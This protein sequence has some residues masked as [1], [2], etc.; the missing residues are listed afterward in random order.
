HHRRRPR[1]REDRRPRRDRVRTRQRRDVDTTIPSHQLLKEPLMK[2]WAN[3]GDSHLV[4]P[5]DLFTSSLPKDLADRMPRSEKDP[6]GAH[7]T[8]FIDGQSFRRQMPKAAGLK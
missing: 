1:H 3:S 8:L 4:E 5:D 7:E 2:I 6:D